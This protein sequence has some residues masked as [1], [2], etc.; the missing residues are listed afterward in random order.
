MAA[1]LFDKYG[2]DAFWQIWQRCFLTNMA[3]MLCS[4]SVFS[5]SI[6]TCQERRLLQSFSAHEV[7]EEEDDNSHFEGWEF[8]KA[9]KLSGVRYMKRTPTVMSHPVQSSYFPFLGSTLRL[10]TMQHSCQNSKDDTPTQDFIFDLFSN[11]KLKWVFFIKN[12]QA[13]HIL[14]VLSLSVR[15][16]SWSLCYCTYIKIN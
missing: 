14:Y 7:S 15:I 1:M 6:S 3:A 10:C 13:P 12:T 2:S 16:T 8:C 9:V 4:L 11:S 5:V